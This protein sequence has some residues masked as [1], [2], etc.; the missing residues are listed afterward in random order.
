[1]VT[2]PK[3][4]ELPRPDDTG[5][6]LAWGVWGD[7]D[8]LGTLNHISEA[9]T[10]AAAACIK[11]GAR[12]NLDLPLNLPYDLVTE[13]AFGHRGT[14]EHTLFEDNFRTLLIRDDKLD[15]FFLQGSSQWDGLTHIGTPQLG[16]Y[17]GVAPEQLTLGPDTRNGIE[18]V[19]NLAVATRGVLI[20][21]P[22]YFAHAGREWNPAEK[23][24]ADADDVQ[25]CLN[26]Q[27]VTLRQG[28]IL[29][30]RF[31]WLEALR[32]ETDQSARNRWFNEMTFAGIAGDQRMW[33]FFWD[34]QVA[35]AAGDN[36]TLEASPM[37]KQ[38]NLHQSI[39]RLG[40]TIGELFDLD[41]LATDSA[42]DGCY[43]SFL[44]T[45][46]LNLRGGV[47]SPPNAIAIK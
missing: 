12:F 1:M 21:L 37:V 46:P 40:F 3:F 33:E 43:E 14:P 8:Q 39:P 24:I 32:N 23:C 44:T 4:S 7:D 45:S 36:P 41:A 42:E 18:H 30:F 34:N 29:L 47:G 17:N 11:R 20:D 9:T 35:A 28:D 38:D 25:A 15:G 26:H 13:G 10:L 19:A 16:F 22:R 31:G 5:Q 6:A 2:T 27:E